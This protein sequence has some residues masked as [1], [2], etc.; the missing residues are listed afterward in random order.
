MRLLVLGARS[1]IGFRLAEAIRQ[2]L[3]EWKLLGTS[4]VGGLAIPGY[5]DCVAVE[6]SVAVEGLIEH[7]RP[8]VIV[9]LLRYENE[10]GVAIHHVVIDA[11][12][13]RGIFYCYM[14][15]A[16]ALDASTVLDL[17]EDLPACSCSPYGHFKQVCEEKLLSQPSCQ[18]LIIRFSSI[19]GWSP[20]KPSRTESL[21]EKLANNQEVSVDQG[22]RQNR[23]LDT[24][25]ASAILDLIRIQ[26]LGIVHLGTIDSS[27][28]AEFL[29]RVAT[30]FGMDSEL[31]Q[32]AKLREVNL[33]VRP[34]RIYDL[35]GSRYKCTEQDT[36][37]GLLACPSLAGF[38][39]QR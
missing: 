15:S 4:S 24:T 20:H 12:I 32:L 2:T 38:R 17:T 25:L 37:N 34:Q 21:L 5:V 1:W 11:C 35:F 28:E 16:L 6:N 23:M 9:N 29:K 33:A 7:Y 8:T 14:S 3:P 19:H 13:R 18:S 27:D 31:I 26:A 39:R 10:L 22:I 36:I 30:A